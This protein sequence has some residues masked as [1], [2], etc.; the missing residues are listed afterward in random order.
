MADAAD[1]FADRGPVAAVVALSVGTWWMMQPATADRLYGRIEGTVVPGDIIFPGSGGH[2]TSR[3]SSRIIP[4]IHGRADPSSSIRI[5][6]TCI[7]VIARPKRPLGDRGWKVSLAI[8]RI[9]KRCRR[10]KLNPS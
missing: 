5:R 2:P 3:R 8:G 10:S 4:M 7:R 1:R 6:S 9:W